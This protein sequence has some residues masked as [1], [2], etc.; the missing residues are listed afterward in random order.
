MQ[1]PQSDP[2]ISIPLAE[3][4]ETALPRDRT[5][6]DPAALQELTLSIAATGLRQPIEVWA[7]SAPEPPHRYGLISGFRRLAVARSLGLVTIPAFLRHPASVAEAMQAMVSENEQR[8]DLSPYERARILTASVEEGI[9]TSL[10]EAITTLHPQANPT[11]RT[12]LRAI[13]SVVEALGP[14]LRQPESLSQQLL[15]RIAAAV[16]QGFE[17]VLRAALTEHG[18]I[19][20]EAQ[21]RRIASI[22]TEAEAE[23]R[24]PDPTPRPPGRP[25]RLLHPRAGLTV[26]RERTDRGW[27]LHFTGDSAHGMMVEDVMD[28]IERMYAP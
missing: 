6:T 3:V 23:A 15:L 18:D 8:S 27:S 26:R 22:L 7:L 9:F 28:E 20:P 14:R 10:D 13:A 21:T 5:A 11:K 4:H 1:D 16:Q 24:S 25:K 2:L 17:P 19:A 12:R